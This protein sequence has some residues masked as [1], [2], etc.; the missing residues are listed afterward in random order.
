[1]TANPFNAGKQTLER[2][3][4]CQKPL[5]PHETALF[6]SGKGNL[7]QVHTK[8]GLVLVHWECA[9]PYRTT[10]ELVRAVTGGAEDLDYLTE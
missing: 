2:C 9:S 3:G 4:I 7:I 5:M 6:R 8:K 1:M 10:S